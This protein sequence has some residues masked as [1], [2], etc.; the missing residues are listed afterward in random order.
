MYV[1]NPKKVPGDILLSPSA[2]VMS[3]YGV[4]MHVTFKGVKL[5]TFTVS[6]VGWIHMAVYYNQ[7]ML[8]SSFF[9][10]VSTLSP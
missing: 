7:C 8:H 9:M 5:C 6:A 1:H 10:G 4:S 2:D 3:T